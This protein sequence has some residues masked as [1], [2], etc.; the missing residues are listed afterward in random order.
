MTDT[1]VDIIEGI[2]LVVDIV[3]LT[4]ASTPWVWWVGGR[5]ACLGMWLQLACAT[6]ACVHGLQGHSDCVTSC[7]FSPDDR[8]LAS[9]S[10]DQ[11]VR[12]W[13][14]ASGTCT[15]T[16]QLCRLQSACMHE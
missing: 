5:M 11:T 9:S 3:C 1:D 12:V 15:S 4:C 6:W 2:A 16:L 14:I 13:D 8:Q 7:C 10:D